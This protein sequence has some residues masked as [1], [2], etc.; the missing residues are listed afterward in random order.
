MS[1]AI[2]GLKILKANGDLV[3]PQQRNKFTQSKPA[4]Q[5]SHSMKGNTLPVAMKPLKPGVVRVRGIETKRRYLAY[6]IGPLILLK[7]DP[8]KAFHVQDL[9]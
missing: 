8:S 3:V 7:A 5:T 1:G 4:K 2:L 6:S 9:E